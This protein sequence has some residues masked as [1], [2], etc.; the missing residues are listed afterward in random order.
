M[1]LS[2]AKTF[3]VYFRTGGTANF[4]WE[5]QLEL[6]ATREAAQASVNELVRMGY[7]AHYAD[8]QLLNSIGLPDTYEAA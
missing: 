2:P 4:K 6:H 7:P 5:R 8:S 3:T 1:K